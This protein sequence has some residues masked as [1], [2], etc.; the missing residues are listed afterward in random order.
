MRI[1]AS[2][3]FLGLVVGC[4]DV[5]V[6]SATP[7][8]VI[9]SSA[10]DAADAEVAN[11]EPEPEFPLILPLTKEAHSFHQQSEINTRHLDETVCAFMEMSEDLA[12]DRPDG[13]GCPRNEK[14]AN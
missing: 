8:G 11:E 1:A 3:V 10:T 5:P 2:V 12:S 6:Q 14:G 9:A 4:R 13:L 7:S